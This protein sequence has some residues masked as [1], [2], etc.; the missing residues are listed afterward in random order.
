MRLAARNRATLAKEV[1]TLATRAP[2]LPWLI[3]RRLS[4]REHP[5]AKQRIL[6]G[7]TAAGV[8]LGVRRRRRQ[9]TPP[10]QPIHLSHLQVKED[11]KTW[12][13]LLSTRQITSPPNMTQSETLCKRTTLPP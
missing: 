6:C 11:L 13:I 8:P 2:A 3:K 12:S 4:N 7:V 10:L 5:S 9:K 1:S